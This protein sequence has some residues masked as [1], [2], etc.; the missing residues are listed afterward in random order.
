MSLEDWTLVW[1][2]LENATAHLQLILHPV[3]D[4]SDVE[5]MIRHIGRGHLS[6]NTRFY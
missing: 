1:M 5:R 4:A 3:N 2:K 6:E